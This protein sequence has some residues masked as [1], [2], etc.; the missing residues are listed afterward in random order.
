V[1]SAESVELSL[2]PTNT[3]GTLSLNTGA[4]PYQSWHTDFQVVNPASQPAGVIDFVDLWKPVSDVQGSV[5]KPWFGPTATSWKPAVLP[6]LEPSNEAWR[7][8][9]FGAQQ[10]VSLNPLKLNVFGQGVQDLWHRHLA[11]EPVVHPNQYLDD[12]TVAATKQ[13]SVVTSIPSRRLPSDNDTPKRH[14]SLP[15]DAIVSATGSELISRTLQHRENERTS[16]ANDDN[17]SPLAQRQ[18]Q[19]KYKG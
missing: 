8:V 14:S 3:L 16:S 2:E 7:E 13:R 6:T 18:N 4:I 12:L 17:A 9:I 10:S 5:D 19:R 11:W 1:P 15:R